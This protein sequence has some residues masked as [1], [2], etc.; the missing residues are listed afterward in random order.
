MG[1][2]ALLKSFTLTE[3]NGAKVADAKVDLGGGAMA[4]A[5]SY[6]S[7]GDD[8]QPLPG[9][10]VI[11]MGIMREGK[12][13]AVGYLDIASA[14]KAGPGEKRAYSRDSGGSEK[15]E[16][17]LK[18]DGTAVLSNENGQ[19]ELAADGGILAENGGVSLELAADGT[20]DAHNQVGSLVLQPAGNCVINNVIIDPSGNI[21]T[22]GAVTGSTLAATSG[23]SMT[24]GGGTVNGM[25][26]LTVNSSLVVDGKE[27]KN[28]NHNITSGSSAPGP[29]GPNN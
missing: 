9:D 26:E 1:L 10:Y 12:R 8:S 13:V 5:E 25:E 19:V 21:T 11:T 16:L 24:M 28:H 7:A 23:G 22:P 27:L 15:A 6:T 2:I 17:W 14:Q 20:I 29:T 3:R 4:T 18:S